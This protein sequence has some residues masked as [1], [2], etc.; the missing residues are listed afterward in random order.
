MFDVFRE[1][2][3]VRKVDGRFLH[4]FDLRGQRRF[5]GRG[6]KLLADRAIMRI[7]MVRVVGVKDVEGQQ[8][9]ARRGDEGQTRRDQHGVSY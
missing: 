2:R 6:Q 7:V 4:P 8:Q 1:F 5:L 3:C 9:P